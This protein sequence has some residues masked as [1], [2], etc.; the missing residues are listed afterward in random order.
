MLRKGF[1]IYIARYLCR[2]TNPDF[3]DKKAHKTF[4]LLPSGIIPYKRYDAKAA[5][6]IAEKRHGENKSFLAI[7]LE[8]LEYFSPENIGIDISHIPRYLKLFNSVCLKLSF[9]LEYEGYFEALT[10]LRFLKE[11]DIT[12][13]CMKFFKKTGKF[14]FGTPSQHKKH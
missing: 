6:F 4:S 1:M 8:L 11:K 13:Y 12:A 3:K 14:L 7:V 5:L 2:R 10:V 9:Y